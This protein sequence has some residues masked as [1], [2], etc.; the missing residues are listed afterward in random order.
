MRWITACELA[1]RRS[2]LSSR[3][4]ICA[5]ERDSV[6]TFSSSISTALSGRSVHSR[7]CGR[8]PSTEPC[9]VAEQRLG[10]GVAL[11]QR[12]GQRLLGARRGVGGER[13]RRV[14]FA[15][16]ALGHAPRRAGWIAWAICAAANS[17][18]PC[19]V[20]LLDALQGF[21]EGAVGG[22]DLA[23]RDLE[24]DARMDVG[25]RQAVEAQDLRPQVGVAEMLCARSRSDWPSASR[26]LSKPSSAAS[27]RRA[28][29]APIKITKKAANNA[30]KRA[31]DCWSLADHSCRATRFVSTC[32]PLYYQFLRSAANR[33]FAGKASG[34]E[35]NRLPG[36]DLRADES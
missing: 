35:G 3:K 21:V 4:V 24:L 36:V 13:R 34:T 17:R 14:P 23:D 15:G 30:R 20:A 7:S 6:R 1:L 16:L 19:S 12:R 28:P 10:G 11:R 9:A 29:A 25:D 31:A 2:R 18:A 27:R 5:V 32:P 26:T 22:G 33:I 8:W